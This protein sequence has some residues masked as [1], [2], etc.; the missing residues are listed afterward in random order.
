MRAAMLA[1]ALTTGI[2][3]VAFAGDAAQAEQ[4]FSEGLAAMKA[5]RWQAACDA[6]AGSNDADP[7]PGTQINLGV[8]NEKQKKYASALTWFDAAARLAEEQG[9]EDRA[10]LARSE[11]ARVAPKVHK[12]VVKVAAPVPGATISR[13]GD[14]IPASLL[15]DRETPLDPGSYTL[16]LS[17]KGKKPI[18]KEIAIP[19]AAGTSTVEFPAMEDAPVETAAPEAGAGD[20]GYSPPIV[21]SDGSGQRTAGIL[22]GGAGLLALLAA[23]GVQIVALNEDKAADESK[24][25]AENP[26]LTAE[27][28][29]PFIT[30]ESDRRQNAKNNQLIAMLVGG[31]GV[32]LLGVGAFLFFTAPSGPKSAKSAGSGFVPVVAPGYAGAAY[33]MTF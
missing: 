17:A 28:R 29:Q 10:K 19:E 27:Q 30:N 32:V 16:E 9:R 8:C 12:L 2:P 24:A 26:D 7:S 14:K 23:G 31:S 1:V 25:K 11:H 13:N 22:V 21:V 5:E 20:G 15:I 33:G 3:N 4:L 6:F 18:A